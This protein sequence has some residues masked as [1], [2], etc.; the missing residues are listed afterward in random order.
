VQVREYEQHH[1]AQLKGHVWLISSYSTGRSWARF[2]PPERLLLSAAVTSQRTARTIDLY[3]NRIAG[4]KSLVMPHVL[5]LAALE[6]LHQGLRRL[7]T[8]RAGQGT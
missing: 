3:L 4:L 6:G 2:F 7:F 8:R 5:V 1:I